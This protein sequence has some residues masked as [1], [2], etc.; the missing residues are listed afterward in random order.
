M[1]ETAPRKRSLGCL[2]FERLSYRAVGSLLSL[3]I[4][5]K[6]KFLDFFTSDLSMIIP[7][8]EN[9][10]T[11]LN[12]DRLKLNSFATRK[13]VSKSCLFLQRERCNYNC[14]NCN[15]NLFTH[16]TPVHKNSFR[17][18]PAF[19]DRIGIWKVEGTLKD[20]G[21]ILVLRLWVAILRGGEMI[22]TGMKTVS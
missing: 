13:F 15:C 2:V 14:N 5:G 7:F 4:E 22:I 21:K 20:F 3:K 1:F 11:F 19:Q 9:K 8:N 17:N 12:K 16:G 10:S 6:I 18:V